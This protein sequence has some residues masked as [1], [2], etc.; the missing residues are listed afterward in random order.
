MIPVSFVLAQRARDFANC[1]DKS[2]V[3]V[4]II[5]LLNNYFQSLI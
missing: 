5:S 1:L 2:F 3:G 4:Q